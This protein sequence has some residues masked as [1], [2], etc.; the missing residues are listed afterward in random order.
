MPCSED[1]VEL[2]RTLHENTP[3]T[4]IARVDDADVQYLWRSLEAIEL[5]DAQLCRLRQKPPGAVHN[6]VGVTRS[7]I[8]ISSSLF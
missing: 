7:F 4:N 1:V 8:M 5:I 6:Q 2:E 3:T